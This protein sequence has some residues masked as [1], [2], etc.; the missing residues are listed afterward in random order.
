MGNSHRHYLNT[1]QEAV[2]Q[3]EGREL[4]LPRKK[5]MELRA[6]YETMK[7]YLKRIKRITQLN[8]KLRNKREVIKILERIPNIKKMKLGELK[9]IKLDQLEADN[10]QLQ[11]NYQRKLLCLDNLSKYILRVNDEEFQFIISNLK[12]CLDSY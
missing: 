11:S 12:V 10:R 1:V 9:A 5:V 7:Q 3:L 8:I 2:T 4:F 6:R